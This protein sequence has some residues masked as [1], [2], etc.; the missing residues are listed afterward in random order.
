MI[1]D[2]PL[3]GYNHTD[4]GLRKEI[5]LKM[6]K[7]EPVPIKDV[8]EIISEGLDEKKIDCELYKV[9][10][11]E[12]DRRLRDWRNEI[13]GKKKKTIFIAFTKSGHVACVGAGGDLCF[14]DIDKSLNKSPKTPKILYHIKEEYQIKKEYREDDFPWEWDKDRFIV[15]Y[16]DEIVKVSKTE[17]DN[18]LKCR[19][20]V[21]FFIGELLLENRVPILNASH[22]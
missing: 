16:L 4:F 20:G 8:A 14:P 13:K 1:D 18:I 5:A 7:K 6:V 22:P 19:D 3:D 21:E 9:D 15:I 17:V 12:S 10:L 2:Y 11:K